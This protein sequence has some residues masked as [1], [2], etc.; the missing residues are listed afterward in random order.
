MIYIRQVAA[1]SIDT[2]VCPLNRIFPKKERFGRDRR[3]IYPCTK[4]VGWLPRAILLAM[5]NCHNGIHGA[6]TP[7]TDC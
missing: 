7:P 6:L 5:P 1:A 2:H 4:E 3:Q